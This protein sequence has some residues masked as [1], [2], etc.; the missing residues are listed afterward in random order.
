M[1]IID[2]AYAMQTR[3]ASYENQILSRTS[4]EVDKAGLRAAKLSNS[5]RDLDLLFEGQQFKMY[6]SEKI[7]ANAKMHVKHFVEFDI[8]DR[9]V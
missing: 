2:F 1:A 8:C 4:T 9:M 5:H 3:F 7:R 6:T